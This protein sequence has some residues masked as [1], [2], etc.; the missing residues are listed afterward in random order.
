[1]SDAYDILIVGGGL[2]G[3]SAAVALARSGRSVALIE[4]QA[5][6]SGSAPPSHDDRTLVINAAS[7]NI[8]DHLDL[9]PAAAA[10]CPIRRIRITRQG[11]F[12]HLTLQAENYGRDEF[13]QVIVA[14]KLGEVALAALRSHDGI[15]EF[16]P[17]RVAD[18]TRSG[19]QVE[20]T[21]DDGRQL[22]A[23]LLIGADGND[24]QVRTHAG[25]H[26]Q[27][28][29]YRQSAMIF[30]VRPGRSTQNTAY[31]RFTLRGPLAL[32]PQPAGRM[33]VV[34]IDSDAAIDEA[35]A[36]DDESLVERLFQRF[37]PELGGFAEPG[38]RAR[39]PLVRQR[40]AWPIAE[41]V[42]VIGNAANAVHPVSAQGF[43]LGLR[44][45]AGLVDALARQ[46]D[47]GQARALQ[48][49][50]RLR[51]ADQDATVRYTDTLARAFTNPSGLARLATGLGLA[52]HAGLPGLRHRLVQ[53]AMGF[54][55]PV[56]TLARGRRGTFQR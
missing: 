15:T 35:M 28:H 25:L 32:L 30:N 19:D 23:K 10:R 13:G 55:Q 54:R 39:Y 18:W 22:T 26:C 6:A 7:L 1:M 27:H 46:D 52:A 21:L 42:V 2:V 12:G 56:A 38:K 31:E 45:V 40:T 51:Q 3:A 47:P 17:A 4:A 44:D 5:R 33:G 20:V 14:R 49:Y 8:L 37:G 11:G 48:H 29:A 36:M 43:N 50:V 34:W 41:R 16:C 24:S 9:L 53:A